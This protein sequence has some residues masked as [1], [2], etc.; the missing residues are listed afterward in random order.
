MGQGVEPV[1]EHATQ[2]GQAGDRA[3]KAKHQRGA[4]QEQ[5]R[6]V[7][8]QAHFP[9]LARLHDVRARLVAAEGSEN[10]VA[11]LAVTDPHQTFRQGLRFRGLE[12]G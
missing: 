5:V 11:E 7:K 2:A 8:D 9:P 12:C 10:D 4:A 3:H 6:E 1:A